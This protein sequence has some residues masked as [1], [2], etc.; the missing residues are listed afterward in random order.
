MIF[1]IS[2]WS[3]GGTLTDNL[4]VIARKRWLKTPQ[5]S[6]TGDSQ[7]ELELGPGYHI[8]MVK[9]LTSLKRVLSVFSKLC[10]RAWLVSKKSGISSNILLNITDWIAFLSLHLSIIL[11]SCLYLSVPIYLG[12]YLSYSLVWFGWFYGIGYLTPNPYLCK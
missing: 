7:L 12:L 10:R 5:N 1:S 2:L 3:I 8:F 4:G 6:W 9:Y 11:C